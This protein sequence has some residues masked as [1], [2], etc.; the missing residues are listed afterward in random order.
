MTT[1]AHA[2]HAAD[3]AASAA[4]ARHR[5]AAPLDSAPRAAAKGAF[6]GGRAL[7]PMV[8]AEMKAGFGWDFGAVRVHDDR[9]GERFA[10]GFH[11]HAATLGTHI[12]FAP[13]RFRPDVPEGRRL[14]AHELAHVV[15][16]Q[17]SEPALQ[18]QGDGTS[19]LDSVLV[20]SW[21]VRFKQNHPTEA[22][23]GADPATVLTSEG[24]SDLTLVLMGLADPLMQAQVEGNASVEGNAAFNASLSA[25]RARW[26][27]RR[28]GALRVHDAPGHLPDCP[29]VV[30]GEYAC[31]T[32]H[33]HPIATPAD[34]HVTVRIFRPRSATAPAVPPATTTT[35]TT[36]TPPTST[37]TPSTT[38]PPTTTTTPPTGT[39]TAEVPSDQWA[40]QGALGYNRHFYLTPSS[41]TDPLAEWAV[42]L[43]GT[44]TH[45]FH[46][47]PYGFELTVPLQVQ[48]SLTTGQWSVATGAQPQYV[49]PFAGNRFQWSVFSQLLVGGNLSTGAA[50]LQ[51]APIGTQI[52]LQLGRG[53]WFQTGFSF[54]P[55]F[56]GTVGSPTSFD[57]NPTFFITIVP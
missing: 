36:T 12:A 39:T 25:R 9:A 35:G 21:D 53:N 42:Q 49:V 4:L 17:R 28:I 37:T 19:G 16:Q 2:E 15:Q 10:S 38:T 47:R 23:L 44:Y 50:Q 51:F 18:L 40:I 57:L 7:D 46:R 14:L 29:R 27:A 56:T 41:P 11:A 54:A 6:E 24:M 32:M 13:G 43:L 31:G 3:T 20:T 26:L 34:R 30:D 33:A 8:A 22:E 45:P 5:G 55:T 48:Y 52:Q 1:F